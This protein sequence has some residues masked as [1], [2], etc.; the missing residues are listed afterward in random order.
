M[1]IYIYCLVGL[2]ITFLVSRGIYLLFS[3]W[4]LKQIRIL[5]TYAFT[6]QAQLFKY[7]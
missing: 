5:E 7:R 3:L 4:S 6:L 1:W 2:A